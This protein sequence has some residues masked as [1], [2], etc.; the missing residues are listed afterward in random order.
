MDVLV[1]VGDGQP[2]ERLAARAAHVFRVP[3]GDPTP[4]LVAE[5]RIRIPREVGVVGPVDVGGARR[6][7]IA[8]HHAGLPVS[9]YSDAYPSPAHEGVRVLPITDPGPAME[10]VDS[11]LDLV[12]DTP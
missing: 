6:A 10:V 1:I 12:G 4:D 9:L 7:A 11:L 2:P 5:L 8:L 3:T